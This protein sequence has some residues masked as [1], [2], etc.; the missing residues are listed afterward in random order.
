MIEAGRGGGRGELPNVRRKSR[1]QQPPALFIPFWILRRCSGFRNMRFLFFCPWKKKGMHFSRW[2]GRR[3]VVLQPGQPVCALR[4]GS[5]RMSCSWRYLFWS[6]KGS[7]TLIQGT[8][9][10]MLSNVSPT[11]GR[12][13]CYEVWNLSGCPRRDRWVPVTC[14]CFCHGGGRCDSSGSSTLAEESLTWDISPGFLCKQDW[15]VNHLFSQYF[16]ESQ[17]WR[18]GRLKA[19]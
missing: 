9:V 3:T 17:S 8:V 16:P 1:P 2:L 12:K 6:D 5:V 14:C 13:F 7:L 11:Y 4:T 10:C 15:K 18:K 19:F